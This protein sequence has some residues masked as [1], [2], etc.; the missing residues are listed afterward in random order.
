[1]SGNTDASLSIGADPSELEAGLN[2]AANAVK[3]AVGNMEA[4]LASLNGAFQK[5]QTTF[6]AFTA[7][8]AG[9]AAFKA[10]ITASN[11][12]ALESGKLAKSLGLTTEQASVMQVALARTG[13]S[14][15]TL[16]NASQKLSKQIFSNA[17]AF[18]TMGIKV[19]DSSGQY[20]PVMDVMTEA[21]SKL[22]EIHNPIQQN[23]AGMQLYSKAWGDIKPLL[24]LTTEQMQES[25]RRARDLHLI[26]GPEGVNQALQYKAQMRDLN[27]V[28]KSL[29]VQFGNQLTPVFVRLGAWMGQEAPAMGKVFATVL[30]GIGFVAQSVWLALK[31]M[32]DSLGAMAA[33]ANALLHGDLE[34]FKA[35]GKARDEQAKQNEEAYERLKANFGKPM[36][37]GTS[38]AA[39]L[40][41]PTYDFEKAKN[42]K[43][44]IV[45]LWTTQLEE[46][47]LK[48]SEAAQAEGTIYRMSLDEEK[49]Y[50]EKKVG[51]TEGGSKENLE[52]RRKVAF[53]GNEINKRDLDA[54][55]ES[56]KAGEVAAGHALQAKLA[57][58]Q[59]EYDRLNAV[60]KGQGKEVEAAAAHVLQVQ[61]ELAD[62]K[63]AIA[64]EVVNRERISRQMDI[65]AAAQ[66][67]L[68]QEQLGLITKAQLIQQERAFSAQRFEIERQSLEDKLQLLKN[69]PTSDPVAREKLETQLMEIRRKY[70]Q[71]GQ[72]LS[73]ASVLEQTKDWRSLF[74][75]L[76][77]GFASVFANIGTKYK[78]LAQVIGAMFNAL[79]SAI[80]N[81]VA[82]MAARWLV[83][84]I[85]ERVMGQVTA[86]TQ[87][88]GNAAVAGSAAFASTAAIP[89][90]GP[91]MAPAA[92]AA[93]YAGA[94][95]FQGM[96]PSAEGGWDIPAGATGI[97]KYHEK[98]MML[99]EGPASVIRNLATNGG[100]FGPA[101]HIHARTDDDVV[102]VGDLKKLLKQMNRSFV[103]VK[104]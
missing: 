61:R 13:I 23:I 41:G 16:M 67:A 42:A 68:F 59:A 81:I 8:V 80:M 43:E 6:M 44:N 15:D 11:D 17:T 99:P 36:P 53:L 1:M 38:G 39:D 70:A 97:M 47:K 72:Q 3:S 65:D 77:S 79:A 24:K 31:D 50:W 62:Q 49:A 92:A 96:I 46:L 66:D 33:Q 35:I 82:Q 89:V 93:A 87:V 88:A 19:K 71:Q 83:Q 2:K 58:A 56:Y 37:Q 69:D 40:D 91:A 4:S 22:K 18:E 102:R 74:S 73:Q 27:L 76:E 98:E 63:R 94:M 90:V 10:V 45:A 30:E 64:D 5:I 25:E 60:Y 26:V 12:W 9:G 21:N 95:A 55:I 84:Q 103:D 52:V 48:R 20:R 101:P 34:G 14:S 57:Y 78:S 104:R 86:R 75:S 51:L 7:A 54:Q 28:G 32:G 100:A 29:E 85:M